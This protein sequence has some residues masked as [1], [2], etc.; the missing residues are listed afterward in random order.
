MPVQRTLPR[1]ASSPSTYSPSP[2]QSP[3]PFAASPPQNQEQEQGK[4][5]FYHPLTSSPLSHLALLLL[6]LH[7][8]VFSLFSAN[9]SFSPFSDRS[10]QVP[11]SFSHLM[12]HCFHYIRSICAMYLFSPEQNCCVICLILLF[13][14]WLPQCL[15][16]I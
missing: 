16:S 2:S 3:T 12:C 11:Q 7:P 1:P 15:V 10:C 6:P 8:H 9:L 13:L 14:D 5:P 4:A